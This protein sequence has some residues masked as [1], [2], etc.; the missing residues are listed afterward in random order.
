MTGCID[1]AALDESIVNLLSS[2]NGSISA[3]VEAEHQ[4]A[5]HTYTKI[6]RPMALANPHY[7]PYMSKTLGTL[8]AN[9]QENERRISITTGFLEAARLSTST[10]LAASE[11]RIKSQQASRLAYYAK[12]KSPRES[13]AVVADAR[14]ELRRYDEEITTCQGHSTSIGKLDTSLGEAIKIW[15]MH[16]FRIGEIRNTVLEWQV[17]GDLMTREQYGETLDRFCLTTTQALGASDLPLC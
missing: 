14:A 7:Y 13:T 6:L 3:A 2:A 1:V 16:R 17:S 4:L 15:E 10:A 12:A 5:I 11:D 9:L 8:S